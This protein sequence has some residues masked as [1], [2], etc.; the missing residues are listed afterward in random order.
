[1][2]T[3]SI[4]RRI[5]ELKLL[6]RNKGNIWERRH[7][8]SLTHGALFALLLIRDDI[9]ASTS[10]PAL[11]NDIELYRW[12]GFRV[13]IEYTKERIPD[14]YM[15]YIQCYRGVKPLFQRGWTEEEARS[16]KAPLRNVTLD[17]LGHHGSYSLY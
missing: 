16:S 14:G 8:H 3:K 7:R 4:K 11:D 5:A 17:F 10:L 9:E 12:R 2:K 15:A 13:R 6:F 1:M